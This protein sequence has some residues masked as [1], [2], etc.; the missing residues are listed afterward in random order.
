MLRLLPAKLRRRDTD[1]GISGFY[2]THP[3]YCSRF[4]SPK[5][6]PCL[7]FRVES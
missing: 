1:V 2:C 6:D 4:P 3:W 5:T 7:G